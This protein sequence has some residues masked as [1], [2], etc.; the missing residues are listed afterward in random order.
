LAA[1]ILAATGAF[2]AWGYSLTANWYFSEWTYFELGAR[3]LIHYHHESLYS[4]GGLHLYVTDPQLQIGPLAFLLIAPFEWLPWSI[5]AALFVAVMALCGLAATVTA[6]RIGQ[7][8]RGASLSSVGIPVAAAGAVV[9]G[10]W[11]YDSGAWRHLDDA[12]ALLLT[13]VSMF[14]IVRGKPWWLVGLLLG[15][16]AAMKPWAVILVPVIFGLPRRD[17]A[18]TLLM[19]ITTAAAWW[20][21]FVIGA[22]QTASALGRYLVVVQPGSVLHLFG[23]H[24]TVQSWLRPT[25]FVLGVGAG[26]V[27]ARRGSWIAAPLAAIAIRV[28]TDPYAYGYY[29]LGPLLFAFIY[30]CAGDSGT[31][32]PALTAATALAEFVLPAFIHSEGATTAAM[33]LAWA[34]A[35]VGWILY[36]SGRHASHSALSAVSPAQP[37]AIAVT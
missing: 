13:A 12:I 3:T 21:P 31:D 22:P 30:D 24:G 14:L 15:T 5:V 29:G 33:K 1:L 35:V 11:G 6:M 19:V 27:I 23:F 26:T 37:A 36:R 34:I 17:V 4:G 9:A 32:L 8:V 2:T 16:A 18:K 25:Q 28:V 7:A 10:I 20:A